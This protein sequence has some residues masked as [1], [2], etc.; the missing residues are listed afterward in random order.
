MRD[1][2]R[3]LAAARRGLDPARS[4]VVA[5]PLR[6]L[7]RTVAREGAKRALG[8]DPAQVLLVTAADGSKYRPV[9]SDS[10]LD[11]VVPVLERH[12]DAVLLAAGPAPE[13]DWLAAQERTGGRLRALGP[14]PSVRELQQAADVYVDSFPFASLTSLLEAGSL[15][16][17]AITYRGHQEDCGVLGADT[18]GVDAHM[19]APS[20]PA[21]F[22][23]AL[24]QLVA[25]AA[26][27]QARGE[28]TEQAIRDTH[29]GAGWLAAVEAL[30]AQAAEAGP[31]SMPAEAER[32]TGRLDVLVDLVMTQTGFAQGVP[33]AVRDHLALLPPRER[34]AAWAG[35]TRA[36]KRPPHGSV[37][38]EWLLD[39]AR[40]LRRVPSRA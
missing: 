4:A 25:D 12:P 3:R 30:Y 37:V 1:S 16:V 38:S 33:G 22:G 2:G 32:G 11:L 40:T 9:G 23:R 21:E 18:R 39:A 20:D 19:L 36:G 14:L 28:R 7:G 17:P 5:R 15:G 35:L 26:E 6:P 8:I 29:T 27:R 34:A 13:G 10:F 24:G 31:P